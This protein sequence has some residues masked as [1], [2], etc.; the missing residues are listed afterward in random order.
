MTFELYNSDGCDF[1][2]NTVSFRAAELTRSI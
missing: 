1:E 2:L